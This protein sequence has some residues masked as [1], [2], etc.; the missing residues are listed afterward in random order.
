MD[1]IHNQSGV[2]GFYGDEGK[3]NAHKLVKKLEDKDSIAKLN[4]LDKIDKP[5]LV[6][7]YH[8]KCHDCV[9]FSETYS[10]VAQ[11]IQSQKVNLDIGAVNYAKVKFDDLPS[12][13]KKTKSTPS[14]FLFTKNKIVGPL[15]SP[16]DAPELAHVIQFL[17]Q[18]QI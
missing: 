9:K 3:D 2:K 1:Q 17:N 15:K 10:K 12:K 4:K 14:V 7:F 13:I 11:M 16:E 6:E 5:M 8:P 18:N